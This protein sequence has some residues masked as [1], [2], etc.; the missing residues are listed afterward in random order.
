MR[1]PVRGA[2]RHSQG[3]PTYPCQMH[4]IPRRLALAV[5]L[6][7]GGIT[8]PSLASETKPFPWELATGKATKSLVQTLQES[9]DKRHLDPRVASAL[10]ASVSD[11]MSGVLGPGEFERRASLFIAREYP[12]VLEANRGR[13]PAV[14][15]LTDLSGG[16]SNAAYFNFV[17]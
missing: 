1:T 4:A 12:Y 17:S 10:T 14:P 6:L 9:A 15:D 5:P 3:R 8:L 13:M 11:A 2:P 16:L 7:G